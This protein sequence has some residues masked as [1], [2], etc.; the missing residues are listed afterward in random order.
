MVF[1]IMAF[2]SILMIV[3]LL[4]WARSQD[5]PAKDRVGMAVILSED[6]FYRQLKKLVGPVLFSLYQVIL[7][8]LLRKKAVWSLLESEDGCYR[9][10]KKL[11]GPVHFSLY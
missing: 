5:E 2:S 8:L 3:A 4:L 6:G 7:W 9:Q 1:G 11:I 10:G